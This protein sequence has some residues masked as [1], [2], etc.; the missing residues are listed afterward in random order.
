MLL[1]AAAV[2]EFVRRREVRLRIPAETCSRAA[3]SCGGAAAQSAAAE[4]C[5][6]RA[7]QSAAEPA[8]LLRSLRSLL[9]SLR[10]LRLRERAAAARAVLQRRCAGV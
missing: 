2:V 3:E 5:G 4:R 7:L 6:G 8:S 9:R 10:S 1:A